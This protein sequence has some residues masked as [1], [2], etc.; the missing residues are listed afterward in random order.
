MARKFEV[1]WADFG[2]IV[3][4]ELL[5]EENP[6]LCEAFWQS[7]PFQTIFAASMSAGEMFKIPI[8]RALP[9]APPE[10][11]RLFPEEPPGILFSLN[12]GSLLLKYGTVAEPFMIPRIARVPEEELDKLRNAA[13]RLRD[14]YFFTKEINIA[15]FRRKE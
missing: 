5:D 10:K 9:L 4:M 3:T 2:I 12:V 13:T 15:T 14:A 8:R 6:D 7:L 11:L 1:D